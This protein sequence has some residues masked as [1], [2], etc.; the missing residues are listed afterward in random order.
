MAEA[1]GFRD[2]L[3]EE[4]EGNDKV[5]D[6]ETGGTEGTVEVDGIISDFFKYKGSYNPREQEVE[7]NP[8]YTHP[9]K[10]ETKED[11]NDLLYLLIR[12][13]SCIDWREGL[14]YMLKDAVSEHKTRQILAFLHANALSGI[15]AL[16]VG[17]YGTSIIINSNLAPQC[18][19]C[20]DW[21][22][23]M[24]GLNFD[25]TS[26]GSV[27]DINYVDVAIGKHSEQK[28]LEGFCHLMKAM[29]NL[30]WTNLRFMTLIKSD[31]G[32]FLCNMM[33]ALSSGCGIKSD[34]KK[35]IAELMG[36]YSHLMKCLGF[37]KHG[38]HIQWETLGENTEFINLV[39][40][41]HGLFRSTESVL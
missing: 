10:F 23:V 30:S 3:K 22:R 12:K 32:I 18:M 1:G 17:G 25:T 19:Q 31:E 40:T 38:Q 33:Q 13:T 11:I 41:L 4:K 15:K 14:M 28:S 29:L 34:C 37:I 6:M 39:H 24:E 35:A 16:D 7:T 21:M 27:R 9:G 2:L 36:K 20:Q 5:V 8:T 26:P